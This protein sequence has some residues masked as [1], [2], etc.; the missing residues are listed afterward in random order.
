MPKRYVLLMAE[1]DLSEVEVNE[2]RSAFERRHPG[3]KVILVEGNTRAAII[4]TT[5]KVAS[6][7]RTPEGVPNLRGKELT[8]VLT[9]GAVGNLKRRALRAAN[10]GQ[11]HE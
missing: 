9:S 2:L 1:S 7:L 8:P 6:L 11:V 3:S 10:N 4:K 5:N